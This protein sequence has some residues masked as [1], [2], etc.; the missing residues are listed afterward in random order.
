MFVYLHGSK[1]AAANVKESAGTNYCHITHND[2]RRDIW[3]HRRVQRGGS[4]GPDPPLFLDPPF[5]SVTPPSNP[6]QSHRQM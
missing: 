2:A 4:G 5:S 1:I 3:T 6:T